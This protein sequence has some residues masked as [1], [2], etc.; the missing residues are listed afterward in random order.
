VLGSANVFGNPINS[1]RTLNSG[2]WDFVSAPAQVY[3]RFTLHS[4]NPLH[5]DGCDLH[6]WP[7]WLVLHLVFEVVALLVLNSLTS[8]ARF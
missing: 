4:W 7:I 2:I 5:R 1:F 8:Q 3:T 6:A